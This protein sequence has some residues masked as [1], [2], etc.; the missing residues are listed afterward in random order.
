M[1]QHQGLGGLVY[2][3]PMLRDVTP[4]KSVRAQIQYIDTYICF[5]L[6][7]TMHSIFPTTKA[8]MDAYME[9]VGFSTSNKVKNQC[10]TSRVSWQNLVHSYLQKSSFNF[11]MKSK[12][13]KLI[14]EGR[15]LSWH[16]ET[17]TIN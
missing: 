10:F 6:K 11:K 16:A 13:N 15:N 14:N 9:F 4:A 8:S 3:T 5:E 1:S 7:E 2:S 17:K 12:T